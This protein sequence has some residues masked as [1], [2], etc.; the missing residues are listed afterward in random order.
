ML[1]TKHKI[2]R[3]FLFARQIQSNCLCL[4]INEA[5]V[6]KSPGETNCIF[7]SW[8]LRHVK[9]FLTP[10]VFSLWEISASKSCHFEVTL[11]GRTVHL[12]SNRSFFIKVSLTLIISP[13]I[14][15]QMKLKLRAAEA[16]IE[17]CVNATK[18]KKIAANCKS[19]Q[20]SDWISHF[21]QTHLRLRLLFVVYSRI[22]FFSPLLLHWN[23]L[24]CKSN[25]SSFVVCLVIHG[26]QKYFHLFFFLS[27]HIQRR[28]RKKSL[29][30]QSHNESNLNK[31]EF[32]AC[33]WAQWT[34]E[35]TNCFCIQF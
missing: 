1:S 4:S 33:N 2:N 31:M 29:H 19:N 23:A 8:F 15:F 13:S 16:A 26:I 24:R 20:P 10:N 6:K 25:C 9:C 3:H 7:P 18:T 27:L 21:E 34:C 35:I 30:C 28:E 5:L 11:S 32:I 17:I 22:G 14:S 12:F